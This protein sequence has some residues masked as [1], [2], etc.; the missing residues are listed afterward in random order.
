MDDRIRV[1]RDSSRSEWSQSAAG[2]MAPHHSTKISGRN[3]ARASLEPAPSSQPTV[4]AV[5]PDM[6]PDAVEN[7]WTSIDTSVPSIARAFGTTSSR[8]SSPR[9]IRAGERRRQGIVFEDESFRES[10]ESSPSSMLSQRGGLRPRTRTLDEALALRQASTKGSTEIRHRMGSFSSSTSQPLIE[11]DVRPPPTVPE[12]AAYKAV[13]PSKLPDARSSATPGK[14][15]RPPGTRQTKRSSQHPIS[16]TVSPPPSVDSLL[17]PIPTDDANRMLSLMKRLCGRMRG[18]AEYRGGPGAPW[19]QGILYIDDDKGSL[20]FDSGHNGPFHITIIEDLRG[21][22]VLPCICPED[23]SKCLELSSTKTDVEII[24]RPLSADEIDLWL[25]SLLCWQQIRPPGARLTSRQ[26]SSS[27][28]LGQPAETRA[29]GS[30]TAGDAPKDPAIIKVGNVMLWDKGVATSPRAIVKRPSTRDLRSGSTSWR[31]VSCILQDN[32][33]FKLM[34]ENDVTVLSVIDLSQLSRSAVQ[35]LDRSVL[36]G[37]FCIA[38]FPVYSATSKQ[39]SIFRP[40]Y[41]ALDSRVLFE[42]WFVL[43]RAFAVPELYGIGPTGQLTEILD[44]HANFGGQMFRVEKSIQVKVTE[45]KFQR[46]IATSERHHSRQKERDPLIGHYLAEVVLDGEV[47]SRTAI[48]TDTKN[49]FWRETVQFSELPATLPYLSVVLKRLDGNLDSLTHQVQASLGLPRSGNLTE[50]VCGVVEVP[51]DKMEKGNDHEQWYPVQDEKQEPIGSMLIR[52]DHTELIV[53]TTEDYQPLS[54]LL[55]Q[56]TTGLTTQITQSTPSMLRRL[57]EIF[58]NIFQVSGAASEWLKTLVEDEIDGVGNQNSMR[59]LRFGQRIGSNESSGSAT[60]RT[61]LVRDM[62]KSLTGEANLLFRGNTLLTQALEFHMRR[63]GKEYLEETLGEKIFEINEIN[64]DCE[65]DPSRI[66]RVED[67]QQHWKLLI[68]LTTELWETICASANKLPLELRGIL[69]YVRAVAE[70]RY[71]DFL[72]TVNY[73]SVS[74]FLF[75]RFICPAILNPKLFGL[76]RDNPRPRAQRTLTLIAKGI[77]ALANLSSFGKKES[78]MENMNRFLGHQRQSF[79]TFIDQL[80]SVSSDRNP[81]T[82]PASYSTPIMILARLPPKG[83][84]GFP[85]L[86]YLIDHQRNFAALVKLWLE[87]HH[88]SAP[89]SHSFKGELEQFHTLCLEL[90]RRSDEC[91]TQVDMFR[92]C[93]NESVITDELAENLDKASLIESLSQSYAGSAVWAENDPY[94]PPG[95][96]G[97]EAESASRAAKHSAFRE[98]NTLRQPPDGLDP[99]HPF[100]TIRAKTRPG[101][102]T[103]R[104]LSGLIGSKKARE[105]PNLSST[106]RDKNRGKEERGSRSTTGNSSELRQQNDTNSRPYLYEPVYSQAIYPTFGL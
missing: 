60:D 26:G 90:Q 11:S 30:S 10:F 3:S 86:P 101:K 7:G 50:T 84:E 5:T 76:L 55:H 74:G 73:T 75:L 77:Q 70:D 2:D 48:Q 37:D 83:R 65:V 44:H 14:D 8:Q 82:I 43:L 15:G 28:R 104:F 21:C 98:N 31:R 59:R 18:E 67:L 88:A 87:V 92:A 29:R 38:V 51:L 36:D 39:L 32:G 64:P 4:R 81:I 99:G 85:S 19:Y 34:T 106:A 16:P 95:S 63:L 33:E 42:V 61:Q 89:D 91:M 35:K 40:V 97:S 94:R 47:R 71:G 41:L 79:K 96:S 1:S 69:K 45:A 72:R 56:F 57:S 17:L 23:G 12:A 54:E 52:L 13:A 105:G 93:E 49:P 68:Q 9:S 102:E 103:R 66:E 6:A 46:T 24:F 20:M 80:C 62:S 53:L 78:W 58:L 27:P 25:A 100:G 22:R